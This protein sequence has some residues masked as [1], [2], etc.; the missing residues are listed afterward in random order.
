M[1]ESIHVPINLEP[2]PPKGEEKERDPK[3][4]IFAIKDWGPHCGRGFVSDSRFGSDLV[5][6]RTN[7]ASTKKWRKLGPHSHESSAISRAELFE[8]CGLTPHGEH[9]RPDCHAQR[10]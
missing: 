10:N 2:A 9:R 8:Y 1:S 5:I 7:R 6:K 4:G 3:T